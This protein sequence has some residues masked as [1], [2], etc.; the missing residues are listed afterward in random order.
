MSCPFL[1]IL[2]GETRCESPCG[3]ARSQTYVP[4]DSKKGLKQNLGAAGGKC[5]RGGVRGLVGLPGA[6]QGGLS[7][8]IG[9]HTHPQTCC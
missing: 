2:K 5:E 9:G 6:L 1:G 7:R 8:L 4:Q 3:A